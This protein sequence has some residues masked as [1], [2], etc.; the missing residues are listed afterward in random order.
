MLG[1]VLLVALPVRA[2]RGWCFSYCI[3]KTRELSWWSEVF[4]L[5]RAEQSS[6]IIC[7]WKVL[8]SLCW[9]YGK[10]NAA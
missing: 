6:R 4:G 7:L 8:D 2:V 3:T 10:G 5:I 9:V 1:S